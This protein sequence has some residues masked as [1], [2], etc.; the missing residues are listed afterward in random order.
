MFTI[1]DYPTVRRGCAALRLSTL[2]TL[3]VTDDDE[4]GKSVNDYDIHNRCVGLTSAREG[5]VLF[6]SFNGW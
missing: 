5:G 6:H 4:K 1:F 2:R 3:M